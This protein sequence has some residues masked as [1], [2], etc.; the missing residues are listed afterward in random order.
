MAR[1][2][3]ISAYQRSHRQQVIGDIQN[4]PVLDNERH[5]ISCLSQ[6]NWLACWLI[7]LIGQ[8]LEADF[9]LIRLLLVLVLLTPA[10][11]HAIRDQKDRWTL[12]LYFENDLFSETDQN[13]TNG[14]RFSW[15][16]PDLEDYI[17]DPAIPPAI[18]QINRKL[19]FFHK[20]HKGLQRNIIASL[21]QTMYTPKDRAATELIEDD[22]PYAGWLYSSFSFQ[23]KNDVQLDTVEVHIG[24]IGP[25]SLAQETQNFIHD[26]RGFERFQ[27]WDNQLENEL[28]LLFLW[29]HKRKLIKPTADPENF[30]YDLISHSGIAIGNVADYLNFGAEFRIGWLIPNDF[31]TSAV[32]PGGDNSAPDVTW[33][34]R[35]RGKGWGMHGFISTDVRL[36]ARDIFLDGNTFEDSHS[37]AK[38]PVVADASIGVSLIRYGVKVSYAQVFRTREFRKQD[39]THSYGSLS[40]S[41]TF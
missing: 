34:P 31:G 17:D 33:D 36:V 24:V 41:Y 4:V 25:A 32:R 5:V 38:E 8:E 18:K 23:S 1:C 7:V 9:P 15:V 26:L 20:S 28:G 2:L 12:N 14:I 39:K 13:Y 29:E 16:S 10:L 37:V 6:L 11:S 22:R 3:L 19:I 27:G 30:S 35:E 21:G 40:I